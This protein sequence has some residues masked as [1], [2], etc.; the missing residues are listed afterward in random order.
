VANYSSTVEYNYDFGAKTR[1]QT[2][3]PN[4]IQNTPGPIQTLQYDSAARLQTVTNN[5]N[6]AYTR[7]EYGATY[8]QSFST[9][10]SLTDEGY[11]FRI[12]DGLGRTIIN[13]G[14]HPGSV[15]GYTAVM[16]V[17]DLMG[18]VQKQSNPTETNGSAGPWQATGDDTGWYYTR[19]SYD[20]KGRPLVTTNPDNITT[21]TASYTGC[22]C[23]GGEVLTLTNEVNRQQK[24]Y[25]DALGRQWKTEIMNSP[26][27]NGVRSVYSTRVNVYNARDQVTNVKQYAGVAPAEASSTNA[28]A[29]CPTGTCQET[30]ATYDPYGRLQTKHVPEQNAGTATVYAYNPD[31]TVY[32]V[33]DARGAVTTYGYN[34]RHLVTNVQNALSGLVTI[35][36]SYGYDAA[37]NRTSMIDSFGSKSYSY[38]QLSQLTI[39]TRVFSGVGTFALSY[40]YNLAGELK[41]ITDSTNMTINYGYDT[42]GRVTSVTG[43]DNLYAGVSNYAS[44]LQYRA[45]GGLKGITDGSNHVSSVLYNLKM[46]P[47]Q[48][49]ISGN[50][51]HQNSITTMME[52]SALCTTRLTQTSIGCTLT[53]TP[54]D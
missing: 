36:V 21:K 16:T 15:G 39:E 34:N 17:Y 50:V 9:V 26:G 44:N 29:S 49:D 46:Q 27:Q 37:G 35:N 54:D 38:S 42:A 45:W 7:Y 3:Q 32:S 30:I 6:N 48:F 2:P 1:V 14:L 28:A 5:F 11:S 10:N 31:D 18:R 53:I 47:T 12:F 40:D 33:T 41:K 4:T 13:G 24:L 51:V 52:G 19:Q 25:S 22:G 8:V 43:S 20:W 23:A